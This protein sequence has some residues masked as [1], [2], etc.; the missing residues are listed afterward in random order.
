V[1]DGSYYDV[2]SNELSFKL[3]GSLA[4][5]DAMTRSATDHPRADHERRDLRPLGSPAI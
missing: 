2:D 5:K 3:A 1:F 4:F